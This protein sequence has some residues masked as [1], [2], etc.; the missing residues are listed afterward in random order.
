MISGV[1]IKELTTSADE[2]GWLYEILRRDDEIFAGFGQ[3]YV[4]AIYPGVIKAWHCHSRQTDNLTVVSGMAKLV[5]T[6][7][8]EGS[9]T[10]GEISEF[11]IGDQNRMLV[12]IPPGV[13]HGFKGMGTVPALALNCPTEVF[14][15]NHPDE[16][17]LPYN[18][19]RIPYDWE[20]KHN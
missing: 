6:D 17:R 13:Y 14:D 3:V 11:F 18:T 5:L 12:Q 15:R 10:Q 2:R 4:T 20:I 8:R 1:K 9:P 16:A 19:D 7:L